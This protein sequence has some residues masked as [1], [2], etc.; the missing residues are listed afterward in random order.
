MTRLEKI[1][2]KTRFGGAADRCNHPL[3]V[4]IDPTERELSELER[5]L[6][7]CPICSR[8]MPGDGPIMA[9]LSTQ[10]STNNEGPND[11]G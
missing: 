5:M 6:A 3:A 2:K 4:I 7:S 1:P 8:W 9:V 10:E 11:I